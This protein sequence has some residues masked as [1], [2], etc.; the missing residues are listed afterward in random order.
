MDEQN[1]QDKAPSGPEG[2]TKLPP[3]EKPFIPPKNKGPGWFTV[4]L[5]AFL[6]SVLLFFGIGYVFNPP[7]LEFPIGSGGLISIRTPK[8]PGPPAEKILLVM[9]VDSN[10]NGAEG[11]DRFKG[12][13]TDSMMLV[14]VSPSKNTVSLVSI[15]R[16]SKVFIGRQRRWVDKINAA[17]A[18][19]G[20][21]LAMET[22]ESSFGVP[23]DNYVAVDS[24]GVRELVDAIGGVRIYVEKPMKYRDNTANLTINFEP[25]HHVLN[26]EQAEG[27]L[28]FRYDELGDIGRIR[29]QQ[30]FV[31]AVAAKLRNPLIVTK[32]PGLVNLASKYV[33]TD[34][35]ADE[36][37][38]L[39]WFAKDMDMDRIRTATMPGYPS[40][41]GISYW[42]VD[43]K[44][45]ESVLDRLILDNPGSASEVTAENPMKVGILYSPQA[46][47]RLERLVEKLERRKFKVICKS[48][49][50]NRLTQVVEHTRRVSDVWT[51]RLRKADPSLRNARLIFAPVGTTFEMNACSSVEDYTIIIGEDIRSKT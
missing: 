32:I 11:E 8:S 16:D 37:A 14:R 13:R 44:A 36:M 22:V 50:Q 3:L 10:Y 4:V 12:T 7:D 17:Y 35:R 23:V 29:R 27:Y 9:G 30:N 20:G 6:A 51:E 2:P 5:A 21:E 33:D 41:Y 1:N 31:S 47:D 38:R 34:L 49:Q 26:G 39:A 46:E 48:G 18:Y 24:E 40:S 19:G 43:G 28:R 15:P 42:V 45:A 25:G